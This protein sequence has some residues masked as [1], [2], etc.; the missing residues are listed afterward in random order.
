M[1]DRR[2]ALEDRSRIDWKVESGVRYEAVDR[3][4][5]PS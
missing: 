5:Q 4:Q 3:I 1:H 2:H